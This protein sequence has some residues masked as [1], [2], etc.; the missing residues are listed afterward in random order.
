MSDI[1][2]HVR[3]LLEQ[4]PWEDTTPRLVAYTLWKARR[5]FWQ[6]VLGRDMPEGKEVS[7]ATRK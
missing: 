4:H 3:K 1:P 5:L 2:P 6:G 7:A